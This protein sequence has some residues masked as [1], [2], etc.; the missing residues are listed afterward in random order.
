MCEYHYMTRAEKRQCAALAAEAFSDY[1]YFSVYISNDAQRKRCLKAMIQCEFLANWGKPGAVFLTARDN[2]RVVAV[3]ELCA[4]GF[5]KPSDLEYIK[6]G[7]LGVLLKG[8]VKQA[9]AWLAMDRQASAPCRKVEGKNWYLSLLTVAKSDEGK[10][11]GSKFLTECLI[12]Y[13]RNAGGETFSLFTNSEINRRFYEKNGFVLFDEKQFE[14]EG[15][16]I[17]SWSYL[18]RL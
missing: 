14:Y 5:R 8:G 6:S 10:G 3:A 17:G 2:G 15:K 4:P 9:G 11:I 12:P 18:I 7:W 1:A 13:A 16:T